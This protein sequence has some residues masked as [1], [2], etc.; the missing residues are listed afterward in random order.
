MCVCTCEWWCTRA[1]VQGPV[2][3]G[4]CEWWCT[5]ASVQGPVY[6]GQCTAHCIVILGRASAL[7]VA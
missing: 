2:Y 6:K 5:R 4:L 1:S 7:R 3:K